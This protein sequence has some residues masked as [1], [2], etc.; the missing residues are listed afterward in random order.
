MGTW[1]RRLRTLALHGE[2]LCCSGRELSYLRPKVRPQPRRQYRNLGLPKSPAMFGQPLPP[3]PKTAERHRGPPAESS[4][5]EFRQPCHRQLPRTA[6]TRLN[7]LRP[8]LDYTRL[9]MLPCAARLLRLSVDLPQVPTSSFGDNGRT[10]D[11]LW[12]GGGFGR[13]G[14]GTASERGTAGRPAFA[15]GIHIFVGIAVRSFGG[16]CGRAASPHWAETNELA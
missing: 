9:P 4:A 2:E 11:G 12:G 6:G 14:P 5:P 15:D 13:R 16:G 7:S 10:A 3:H 1:L 8:S